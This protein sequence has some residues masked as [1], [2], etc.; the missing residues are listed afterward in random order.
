ME[1]RAKAWALWKLSL[2]GAIRVEEASLKTNL[3]KFGDAP[4][5]SRRALPSVELESWV[6]LL[7]I[8]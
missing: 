4:Y 5:E 6:G 7:I 8:S 2:V 3:L 1:D